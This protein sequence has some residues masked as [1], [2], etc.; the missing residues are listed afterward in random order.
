MWASGSIVV[1]G[2]ALSL[3]VVVVAG[4]DVALVVVVAAVVVAVGGCGAA[5]VVVV[6]VGDKGLSDGNDTAATN[7]DEGDVA[8]ALVLGAESGADAGV[9]SVAGA[10]R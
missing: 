10:K 3:V 4:A 5:P 8:V 7:G 1:R 2:L 6:A 9:G